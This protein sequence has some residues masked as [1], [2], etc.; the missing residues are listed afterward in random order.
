M[1]RIFTKVIVLSTLMLVSCSNTLF[2]N[3]QTI[4]MKDSSSTQI[5]DHIPNVNLLFKTDTMRYAKINGGQFE[6]QTNALGMLDTVLTFTRIGRRIG[7]IIASKN[8]YV[9]DTIYFVHRN[10]DSIVAKI[11]LRPNT[12]LKPM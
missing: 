2:L 4:T 1:I 5:F 7:S 11:K 3:I 6:L 8:G 12:S 10:G 9:N